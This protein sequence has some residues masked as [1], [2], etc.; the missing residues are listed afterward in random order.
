MKKIITP[1][2]TKFAFIRKDLLV[3]GTPVKVGNSSYN[4]PE[5]L[6]CRWENNQFQVLHNKVW[7]NADRTDFDLVPIIPLPKKA[8]DKR[9]KRVRKMAVKLINGRGYMHTTTDEVTLGMIIKERMNELGIS[10]IELGK[11]MCTPKA[12]KGIG[13]QGVRN[14]LL[15]NV[16]FKFQTILDL[17]KILKYNFFIPFANAVEAEIQG[18]NRGRKL[19]HKAS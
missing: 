4:S 19:L 2:K 9:I 10:D 11:L 7:K 5:R 16:T 13:R 14:L 17:S 18:V 3:T 8:K 15:N 6:E 12:P 1:A